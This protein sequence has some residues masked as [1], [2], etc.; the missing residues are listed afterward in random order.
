M[1]AQVKIN[2]VSCFPLCTEPGV[3]PQGSQLC[4]PT[5]TALHRLLG[6]VCRNGFQDDGSI[7]SPGTE[8]PVTPIAP[9]TLC[10]PANSTC[11]KC[12]V[13]GISHGSFLIKG[14][15]VF[16]GA[17]RKQGF[18][19]ASPSSPLPSCSDQDS[20]PRQVS[21]WGVSKHVTWCT[22]GSRWPCGLQASETQALPSQSSFSSSSIPAA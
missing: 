8:V 19:S 16:S 7:P 18:S 22:T 12:F 1:P 17:L 13:S 9:H 3:S 14:M 5:L 11:T 20:S 15:A 2:N 6:L 21:H 10:L 4:Q